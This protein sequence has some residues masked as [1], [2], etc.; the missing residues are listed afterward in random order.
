MAYVPHLTPLSTDRTSLE[1]RVKGPLNTGIKIV[2]AELIRYG[3]I[4]SPANIVGTFI[5]WSARVDT[6][7]RIVGKTGIGVDSFDFIVAH[8]NK[9]LRFGPL[10]RKDRLIGEVH[11]TVMNQAR[12]APRK[13]GALAAQGA[14]GKKQPYG[15]GGHH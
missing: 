15:H 6:E 5:G 12:S 14:G 8:N 9:N 7:V 1:K 11:T 10:G 3:E 2:G 13:I 4:P